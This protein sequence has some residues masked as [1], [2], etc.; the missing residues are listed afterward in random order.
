[1]HFLFKAWN[2]LHICFAKRLL[3]VRIVLQDWLFCEH[4]IGYGLGGG[5]V[6]G[7]VNSEQLVVVSL[8]NNVSILPF[9]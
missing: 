5:V 8:N 4:L 7:G 3:L 9:C 6:G 1:M 2:V